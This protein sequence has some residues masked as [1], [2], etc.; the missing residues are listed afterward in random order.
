MYKI[1]AAISVADLFYKEG[2]LIVKDPL[3]QKKKKQSK[4]NGRGSKVPHLTNRS[5]ILAFCEG[6]HAECTV[7]FKTRNC[8]RQKII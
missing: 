4:Q 2:T 8:A 3:P 1:H 5:D 6:F 7:S